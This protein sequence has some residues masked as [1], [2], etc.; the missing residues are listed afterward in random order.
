MSDYENAGLERIFRNKEQAR[1]VNDNRK[2]PH[3][4]LRVG[5]FALSF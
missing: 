3:Y 5:P 4:Q 2:L 1:N